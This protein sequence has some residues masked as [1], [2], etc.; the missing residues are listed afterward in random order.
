MGSL[1]P[2]RG[3]EAG[4]PLS[5]QGRAEG[6]GLSVQVSGGEDG[7]EALTPT[8]GE[9]LTVEPPDSLNKKLFLLF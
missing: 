1:G 9:S 2:P 4:H 5:P 8:R 6:G 7:P 3:Y